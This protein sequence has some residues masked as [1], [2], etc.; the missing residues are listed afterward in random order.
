MSSLE[1]K[2]EL[3]PAEKRALLAELLR[4]KA[5]GK[6]QVPVSFA[7]QRLW[8]LDQL[9][10]ENASYNI[11]RAV[12]VKGPLD[13]EALRQALN[14]I[15]ARHESLR[16][17]FTS[18]DDEP[19]Q[20]IAPAREIEIRVVDLS[21]RPEV[22]RESEARRLASEESQ[23]AFNIAHDQLLRIVL[24]RLDDDDQV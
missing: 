15:V 19:M 8:F 13:L 22:E 4:Q 18:I 1:D 12:R 11:S 9:E 20:V 10:P 24:F 5:A 16:T 2:T 17:N 23:R 7:Q 21:G 14:A 6:R 3:L